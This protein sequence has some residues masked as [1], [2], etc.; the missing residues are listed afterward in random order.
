MGKSPVVRGDE[1]KED[2]RK[3]ANGES[4]VK[5]PD[6]SLIGYLVT[7]KVLQTIKQAKSVNSKDVVNILLSPAEVIEGGAPF[8][9]KAKHLVFLVPIDPDTKKYANALILREALPLDKQPAFDPKEHFRTIKGGYTSK[10][11]TANFNE[12]DRIIEMVKKPRPE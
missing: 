12:I 6:N 8:E 11:T 2:A 9:N 7:C 4:A 3:L 1:L 5:H 10:V